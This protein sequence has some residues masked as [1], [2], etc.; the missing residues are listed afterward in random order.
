MS[1]PAD[2]RWPCV[3]WQG[4]TI[5]EAYVG[6]HSTAFDLAELFAAMAAFPSSIVGRLFNC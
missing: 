2:A 3:N 4:V 1:N 5:S 6:K